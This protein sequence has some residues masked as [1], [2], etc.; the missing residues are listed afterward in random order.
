MQHLEDDL[1]AALGAEGD[2]HRHAV[3]RR[4]AAPHV[5]AEQSHD[6][7]HGAAALADRAFTVQHGTLHGAQDLLAAEQRFRHVV[8]G[9]GLDGLH[10]CVLAALAGQQD[11]RGGACRTSIARRPR[12]SP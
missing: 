11:D 9:A 5:V 6:A 7:R 2:M 4:E 10:G 3:A 8:E 1:L 12:A